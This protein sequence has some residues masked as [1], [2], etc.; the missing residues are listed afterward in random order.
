MAVQIATK[1]IDSDGHLLEDE[2]GIIA[3]LASR[4]QG[5]IL[6]G[7]LFPPLDHMHSANGVETPPQRDGRP[8]V[9]PDGWLRFLADAGIEWTVLYPTW[10]LAYGKVV[11]L[12]YAVALCRAYNDWLAETYLRRDPRFKGM[13]II[14]M[15]DPS[16]AAKEL[17]R[18]VTELG[19][20]GAMLPSNGLAQPLGSKAYWPVY[21]E[22]NSLGCP[23]A[24]HGGCHD[25]FGLDHMN[26]YVP[27][28]ALGH[29]WGL[30]LNCANI[31]Y[32]GIF[33]RFPR[34]RI[35][36]L[37]GGIAWLLLLL[38]RLHASHETHFQYVPPGDFG[39]REGDDPAKYIKSLI[40]ADRF[41]IGIETEELTMPFA[42]KVVGNRGFLY[43]S[44]FPHEVTIE[45][46]KHDIGELI[47]SDEITQ[48]D[49]AAMLYRNAERFYQLKP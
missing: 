11:N 44:D 1:I 38:E 9:G 37:E 22:A 14:P 31:L 10:A 41:Y 21:E 23:L 19:M 49:K 46:C 27:V 16:E 48:D 43:S 42:V 4:Y 18:A 35:A 30:T 34:V 2:A 8:V 32:N 36:F 29:P 12:D 7:R 33:D 5:K 47:E 15:Q 28:H 39:V 6:R 17:H 20:L 13:A 24:V 40:A 25:R 26:M 3:H 45:S